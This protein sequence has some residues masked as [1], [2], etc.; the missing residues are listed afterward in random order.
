MVCSSDGSIAA[1]GISDTVGGQTH[2]GMAKLRGRDTGYMQ[3]RLREGRGKIEIRLVKDIGN[4]ERR[5]I[6]DQMETGN[7][8]CIVIE[9]TAHGLTSSSCGG[10]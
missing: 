5:Q 7:T 4:A 3:E 10:L 9:Y 2:R 6:K 1:I 8:N